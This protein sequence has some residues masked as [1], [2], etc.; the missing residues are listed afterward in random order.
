MVVRISKIDRHYYNALQHTW[1]NSRE[2]GLATA[3]LVVRRL[4]NKTDQV[5]NQG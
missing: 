1:C 3:G 2:L 4:R 5:Y